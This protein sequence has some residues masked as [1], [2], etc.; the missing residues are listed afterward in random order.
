MY[1]DWTTMTEIPCDSENR[2]NTG[3]T[4]ILDSASFTLLHILL[5]FFVIVVVYIDASLSV[6]LR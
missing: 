3:S 1:N 5:C 2:N 6:Q 4:L